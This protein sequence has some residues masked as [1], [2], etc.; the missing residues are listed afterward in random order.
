MAQKQRE[1]KIR[2][3][4]KWCIAQ[5]IFVTLRQNLKH[6]NL[7]EFEQVS[8]YTYLSKEIYE[9]DV[10]PL[11][12]KYRL[13]LRYHEFQNENYNYCTRYTLLIQV[14]DESISPENRVDPLLKEIVHSF[15]LKEK[16]IKGTFNEV[17]A[18]E[19]L[20]KAIAYNGQL[21]RK[22]LSQVKKLLK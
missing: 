7:Q 9:Y 18:G 21:K 8:N 15:K 10:P 20:M 1:E 14:D 22:T 3:F 4:Q 5:N 17:M 12:F 13:M 2:K 6:M 16:E 19:F 11:N